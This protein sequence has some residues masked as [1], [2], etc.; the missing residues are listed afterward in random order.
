MTIIVNQFH[1]I[2]FQRIKLLHLLTNTNH[3]SMNQE[4]MNR[5]EILNIPYYHGWIRLENVLNILT[6]TNVIGSFLLRSVKIN[7]SKELVLSYLSTD[8]GINHIIVPKGCLQRKTRIKG[9][10]P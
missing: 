1:D 9:Y 7:Q 3:I 4:R 5:N 6:S 10:C 2:S 8:E